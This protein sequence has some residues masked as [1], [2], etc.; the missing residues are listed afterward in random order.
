MK[1]ETT[2]RARRRARIVL[3]GL[4]ATSVAGIAALAISA[5]A[6]DASS[7]RAAHGSAASATTTLN[8]AMVP[9]MA[10]ADILVA[11]KQGYFS[12]HHLNVNV[13]EMS[14]GETIVPALQSGAIQIG[15]SNLVSVLLGASN[16]IKEPCFTGAAL[17]G[18]PALVT[19]KNSGITSIKQLVGKTI[20]V[21]AVGGGDQIVVE[22]YL[23]Q[24]GVNPSK[25]HIIG[26]ED[27]DMQA[28][29]S[30]NHIAAALPSEPF[31][32]MQLQAG[33]R[34][35]INNPQVAVA[36]P[37]NYTC[38]DANAD[39]LKSHQA[40]AS[41]FAAAMNQAHQWIKTHPSGF[42]ALVV[43]D[44]KID[45]KVVDKARLPGFSNAI[46]FSDIHKWET[47]AHRY[48]ILKKIPA[49]SDVL[50]PLKG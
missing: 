12:K 10:G 13:K 49:M 28:A 19:G 47:L 44:L 30:A 3:R 24:H 45:K 29:L 42:R 50:Q 22:A 43:K 39:W 9:V 31:L 37:G 18:S 6:A 5:A 34:I 32:T 16:G 4:S 17:N 46:T 27:P 25:V 48:G 2:T 14:G 11:Q 26:I 35:L 40:Q 41:D 1:A 33:S 38:W 20:A 36:G 21:N 15:T 8:V 7:A 23:Q